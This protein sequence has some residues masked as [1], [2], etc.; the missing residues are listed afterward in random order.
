[1]AA[2]DQK[3]AGSDIKVDLL[4][5]IDL[6]VPL[7]TPTGEIKSITLR[8]PKVAEMVR[9]QGQAKELKL[10]DAEEE[11]LIYANL[12]EEKLTMEDIGE[13]DFGDFA[14]FQRWFRSIQTGA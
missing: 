8:R 2:D 14:K 7:K 13:L 5:R 6:L 3:T 4:K 10:T 11:L 12:S 1:M 9:Y